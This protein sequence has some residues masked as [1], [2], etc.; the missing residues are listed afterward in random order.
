MCKKESQKSW[1]RMS[2]KEINR[3]CFGRGSGTNSGGGGGSGF[4]VV[5][6]ESFIS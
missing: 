3:V 2:E 1:R 4:L 5:A 6:V